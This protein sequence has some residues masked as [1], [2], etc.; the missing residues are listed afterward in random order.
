M[1]NCKAA[2]KAAIIDLIKKG[3]TIY[4]LAKVTCLR[5]DWSNMGVG[6]YLSQKHCDCSSN[7]PDCCEDGWQVTL[8]GSRFLVGAEQRYVAIEGES[9]SIAWALE[10]TKYFTLGCK[11]L[12]VVTDHEPLIGI[13]GDKELNQ[14]TNPRIFR[15]KQRTLPW[16]F[17]IAYLPVDRNS[18]ADAVSRKKAH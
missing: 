17:D 14:I 10:Q 3:V 6:Y 7:L 9:L 16:C 2:S 12:I 13:F 1:K 8:A 4:D 15:L 11:Q 18:A 5:T